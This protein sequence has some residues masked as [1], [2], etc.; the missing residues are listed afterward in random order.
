[1]KTFYRIAC[2]YC[3][4]IVVVFSPDIGGAQEP[5]IIDDLVIT[6]IDQVDVPAREM[7]ALES[8]H[9]REGD[10]VKRGDV[11]GKLDD[12]Q[13]QVQSNLAAT[14]L[15]IASARAENYLADELAKKDLA[16]EQ[17]LA[18]QQKLLRDIAHRTAQN[19]VRVRASMKAEGVAKSE[20]DRASEAR[21]KFVDS[22]S[23][24]EIE[25]LRL[26]FE[27]RQLETRQASFEQSIDQMK[28]KS[29][30]IASSLHTLRIEQADVLLR[31][32]TT[33]KAVVALE[34]QAKQF[35]KDLSE[36]M[37]QQHQ[38]VSPL[39][40]VIMERYRQSGEWVKPGD[41]IVRVVRL[42][43]LRAEG[44]I[45]ADLAT[46]LRQRKRVRLSRGKSSNV[47]REGRLVFVSSEINPI[48]GQ[49]RI[50]VEFDNPNEDL[51]PGMHVQLRSTHEE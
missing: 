12:R 4:G 47:T 13:I 16:Q 22:V 27:Q 45:D 5:I 23:K 49:V 8:L 24:S 40:G 35:A 1:M 30:V 36:V 11:I 10:R 51:L 17:R 20:W 19:D 46:Q 41:P 14:E 38:I 26:A 34:V 42:D 32:A 9:V 31:Q 43:R 28:A 21:G 37:V 44:Y 29:E 7:G 3:V 2:V 48:N 15:A 39:D 18:E 50:L 33:E 25:G 6:L